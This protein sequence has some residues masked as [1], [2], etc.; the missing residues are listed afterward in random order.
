MR[1]GEEKKKQGEEERCGKAVKYP[2][3]HMI[4][5][6]YV[7]AHIHTHMHTHTHMYTCMSAL[8]LERHQN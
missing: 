5:H 6:M 2:S 1:R 3:T 7:Y 8:H 4:S